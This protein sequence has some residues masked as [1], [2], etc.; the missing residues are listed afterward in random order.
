MN[1]NG[2]DEEHNY[3]VMF[4]FDVNILLS[5]DGDSLTEKFRQIKEWADEITEWQ[6]D[7]S[8]R[9]GV[10]HI[11]IWFKFPEHAALCALRWL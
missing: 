6:G 8:M 10:G 3:R 5:D 11:D 9:A 7:Y 4:P 2:I 1:I